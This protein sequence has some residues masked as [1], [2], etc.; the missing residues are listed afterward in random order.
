MRV[1]PPGLAETTDG[2]VWTTISVRDYGR[3]L[4]EEERHQLFQRFAQVKP[5]TDGLS[6]FGL[7]LYISKSIGASIAITKSRHTS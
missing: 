6:G 4:S 5:N 3:G 1:A 7:G 2:S